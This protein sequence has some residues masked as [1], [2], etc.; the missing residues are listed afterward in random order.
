MLKGY[1][2]YLTAAGI[3]IAAGL[4]YLGYISDDLFRTIE[5]VLAGGGLAALR[6]AVTSSSK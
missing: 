5:L 2:T 1:R 4:H 6:A 3:A